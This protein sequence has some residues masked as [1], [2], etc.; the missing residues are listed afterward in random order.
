MSSFVFQPWQLLVFIVSASMTKVQQDVIRYVMTENQVLREKLRFV[1][2]GFT[3]SVFA[4]L[5]GLFEAIYSPFLFT[6][7]R[8]LADTG[9]L[10]GRKPERSG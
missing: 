2:F 10:V 9:P 7:E 3:S 1:A 8:A 5:S 6:I 4:E